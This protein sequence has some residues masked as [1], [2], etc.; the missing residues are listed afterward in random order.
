MQ[1]GPSLPAWRVWLEAARPKT[2]PAAVVPVLVGAAL[3]YRAGVFKPGAGLICLGFALLVQI[4]TNLANDYGD[5][6][7]GADRADRLGPRR[8]TASGAVTP[9]AM[10]GT[11]IGVFVAAFLLGLGL[12][13][14]GGWELLPVGIASL[15][16]GWAYTS[17]PFPLAYHGLGD[18][19]VFIFFGLVAVGGTFYV[20]TGRLD[21]RVFLAAVPVGLLATNIL[22]VNNTRDAATDARAGKRTLVVRLGR[23]AA[24]QQYAWSFAGAFAVPIALALVW[25]DLTIALPVVLFPLVPG[26]IRRLRTQEGAALNALLASTAQLLLLFGFLWAGV[27]AFA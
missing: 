16:F 1:T 10:A 20:M 12:V 2:L 6:V 9:R 13:R 26:L 8:A 27:L 23:N 7:K 21:W 4:G 17:G 25:T 3:A 18:V 22:V 19:F 15:L 5:F 11:A 14:V 24:I